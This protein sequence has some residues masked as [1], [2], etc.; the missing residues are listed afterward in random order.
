MPLQHF[1]HA[2]FKLVEF[3]SLFSLTYYLGYQGYGY[4]KYPPFKR[5]QTTG[6]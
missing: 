1:D 2:L 6:T 5:Y 3:N 4:P